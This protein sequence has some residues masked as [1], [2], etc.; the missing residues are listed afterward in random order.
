MNSDKIMIGVFLAIAM[1]IFFYFQSMQETRKLNENIGSVKQSIIKSNRPRIITFTAAWCPACQ[2]FKPVLKKVML[3][4][5]SS[6]DCQI[7]NIEDKQNAQI[8]HAFN[9]H[10]IPATYIFDRKG[11]LLVKQVGFIEPDDLDQ[12]LRKTVF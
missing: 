1:A 4:Y 11:N 2:Q 10:S 5:A 9:V 7:I 6:I 8:V 3:D 12:D